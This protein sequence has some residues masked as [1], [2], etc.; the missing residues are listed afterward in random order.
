LC[1][2]HNIFITAAPTPSPHLHH[3]AC[4]RRADLLR[5]RRSSPSRQRRHLRRPPYCDNQSAAGR[6]NASLD[7]HV[8]QQEQREDGRRRARGLVRVQSLRQRGHGN[9]RRG[10][11]MLLLWMYNQVKRKKSPFARITASLSPPP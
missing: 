9:R 11:A 7:R 2:T 8:R 5:R 3:D 1:M 6:P 4:N 10:H